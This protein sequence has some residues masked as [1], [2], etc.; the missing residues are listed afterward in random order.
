MDD[1]GANERG[2]EADFNDSLVLTNDRQQVRVT[3]TRPS[4][5]APNAGLFRGMRLS[6]RASWRSQPVVFEFKGRRGLEPAST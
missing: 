2:G 5:P 4:P 1:D 3:E 6:R